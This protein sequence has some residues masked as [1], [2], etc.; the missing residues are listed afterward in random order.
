MN[1]TGDDPKHWVQQQLDEHH[2]NR[3]ATDNE[4][5]ANVKT[6]YNELSEILIDVRSNILDIESTVVSLSS[7]KLIYSY[8]G[9]RTE[10]VKL[11]GYT[12]IA[13]QIFDNRKPSTTTTTTTDMHTLRQLHVDMS[14]RLLPILR[15]MIDKSQQRTT[16]PKLALESYL[17]SSKGGGGT[18]TPGLSY[19]CCAPAPLYCCCCHSGLL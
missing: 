4:Q 11:L 8:L 17:T 14:Q 6:R 13:D 18:N 10:Q 15:Q 16:Q 9:I 12:T 5:N 7:V 19:C 1:E 3:S 2:E